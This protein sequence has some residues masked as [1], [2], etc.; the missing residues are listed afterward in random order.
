MNNL[1]S[2][3]TRNLERAFS[4]NGKGARNGSRES[5][6]ITY[7]A[8]TSNTPVLENQV[9]FDFNSSVTTSYFPR[10]KRAVF[11]QT[12]D[13][14]LALKIEQSKTFSANQINWEDSVRK[15]LEAS[16]FPEPTNDLGA[17]RNRNI[18]LEYQ[19][20]LQRHQYNQVIVHQNFNNKINDTRRTGN[21][22]SDSFAGGASDPPHSPEKLTQRHNSTSNYQRPIIHQNI[23]T[24]SKTKS[25]ER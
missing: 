8:M 10:E 15:K 3:E 9:T 25:R 19:A 1:K 11:H 4:R 17:V 23:K 18:N 12:V 6:Q 2:G 24:H 5:S 14:E 21:T 7:S 13:R 16:I 22:L 20:L